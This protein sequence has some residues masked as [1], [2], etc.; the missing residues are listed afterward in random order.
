MYIQ[1]QTSK[2][3]HISYKA[4]SKYSLHST[5]TETQT[6]TR[7][8]IHKD[9][10]IFVCQNEKYTLYFSLIGLRTGICS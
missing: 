8:S 6:P 5:S 4:V 1:R 2:Y 7:K 3:S 9:L 10:A